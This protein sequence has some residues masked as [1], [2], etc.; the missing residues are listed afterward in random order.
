MIGEDFYSKPYVL[1]EFKASVILPE[2]NLSHGTSD[3]KEYRPDPSRNSHFEISD[4]G[5]CIKFEDM[6]QYDDDYPAVVRPKTEF[7]V[8]YVWDEYKKKNVPHFIDGTVKEVKQVITKALDCYYKDKE[9]WEKI[10]KKAKLE[11]YE[12]IEAKA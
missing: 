6:S 9:I 10:F 5:R 2:W 3:G 7:C 11:F 12:K 4:I 1:S 8:L